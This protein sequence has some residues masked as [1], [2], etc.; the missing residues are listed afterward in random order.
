VA[1]LIL[2]PFF[3]MHP[4]Y[5]TC[6]SNESTK[7]RIMTR[8]L[9]FFHLPEHCFT[10][11]SNLIGNVSDSDRGAGALRFSKCNRTSRFGLLLAD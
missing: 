8:Q 6:I 7:Y 11:D 3:S 2:R 10:R 4:F 1:P 9:S 5:M